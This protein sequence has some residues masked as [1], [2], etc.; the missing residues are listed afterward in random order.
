MKKSSI[1]KTGIVAL[2]LS[3]LQPEGLQAQTLVPSAIA[4]T[5]WY[6]SP[7]GS[8]ILGLNSAMIQY[9]NT[10]L[11][12]GSLMVSDYYGN[13][14]PGGVVFTDQPPVFRY[15]CLITPVR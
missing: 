12:F 3:L 9:N 7:R 13:G 6:H 10:T 14:I 4:D 11:G 2:L 1:I 8:Y 5:L 15:R